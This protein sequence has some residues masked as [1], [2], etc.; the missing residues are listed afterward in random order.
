M[1]SRLITPSQLSLFSISPVLEAWWEELK[2][3]IPLALAEVVRADQALDAFGMRREPLEV[4]TRPT[5]RF[6]RSRRGGRKHLIEQ[7]PS[8]TAAV[9]SLKGI[10]HCARCRVIPTLL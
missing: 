5:I 1:P 10:T 3:C 8:V 7:A 4:S 2:Q 9:Q 6:T